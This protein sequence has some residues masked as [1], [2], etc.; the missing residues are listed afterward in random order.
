MR[1]PPLFIRLAICVIGSAQISGQMIESQ[2]VL[3][4]HVYDS[5]GKPM[6][7]AIIE[8]FS[9]DSGNSGGLPHTLSDRFGAYVL[10]VPF[11]GNVRIIAKK[12]S[13]GY[14]DTKFAIY[15]A[16]GQEIP[17]IE[18]KAGRILPDID[19]HL[20]EPGGTLDGSIIDAV[21]RKPV[22][23]AR[24]TIRKVANRGAMISSNTRADGQFTYLLPA[25][26]VEIEISAP[27]YRNWS[28]KNQWGQNALVVK[29]KTHETVTA[30]LSPISN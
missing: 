1:T 20:A 19:I 12:E 13:S 17:E 22:V 2:P 9:L 23:N 8:A 5:S 24:V 15:T 28:Y 27:G 14:P 30:E 16:S 4:G 18:I 10:P 6:E 3:H 26:P 11:H 7:A 29:S 21:T 25:D